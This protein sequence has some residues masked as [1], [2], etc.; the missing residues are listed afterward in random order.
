MGRHLL[1]LFPPL[2]ACTPLAPLLALALPAE[3]PVTPSV[4]SLQPGQTYLSQ[5]LLD[6]LAQLGVKTFFGVP[7]DFNLQFL[8]FVEADERIKWIGCCNELNASYAAD[9]YSR[10]KQSQ[11]SRL[12]NTRGGAQGFSALL[13]TYGV[14]E[15]SCV[16]GIAGSYAE[17]VPLI[18]VVGAPSTKLQKGHVML[19]HTLGVPG[20]RFDVFKKATEDMTC[21]QAYLSTTTDHAAEIDRVLLAALT[22]AKPAYLTLPTDLVFASVDATRLETPLVGGLSSGGAPNAAELEKLPTGKTVGEETQERLEFVVKEVERLWDQ[23]KD[24]VVIVD[25]CAVRYGCGH[26]VKQLVE[27]TGV[28]WYTTPMGRA[29][30]MDEDP[31][32][33]YGGVYIAQLSDDKIREA[34]EK[35]DLAIMVG[36]IRSDLNTGLW[37]STIK[38]KNI[39]ELHST[40]TFVQFASYEDISF[41]LLLPVL[42]KVLKPK[43]GLR[44]DLPQQA[45]LPPVPQG[46]PDDIILHEV[47]WPLV[48]RFL[49]PHDIVV[50]EVGT[51]AFGLLTLP[52]PKGATVVSQI[53]WGSIGYTPGAT[54]GALLAAQESPV[55]RRV[56]LFVGDGSFQLS[57]QEVATMVRYGLK[58]TIVLLNNEGCE[59]NDIALFNWSH[60]LPLFSPASGPVGMHHVAST[61]ADLE[62]ILADD[63]FARADKIQVLEIKL[64]KMDAP[65]ALYRLGEVTRQVN[66]A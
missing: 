52:L 39:V 58:P 7:G 44:V 35:T 28:R 66:S 50:A 30:D 1:P 65:K 59:Y 42:A 32:T 13:T 12:P 62:R 21:A 10:V 43:Q 38:T 46:K 16:N 15:L 34:V 33:G 63:E 57:V 17:R 53:L 29:I 9:G 20:G 36:A 41:H 27:A 60:L 18:H 24:P 61:R 22:T 55:P 48:G 2:D 5:Y 6:R 40:C 45:V 4:S 64:G 8:D 14:G 47:L 19:H 26:L 3:A 49:K 11:L 25:G 23:A 31:A 37:S 51:A 54:L 56:L